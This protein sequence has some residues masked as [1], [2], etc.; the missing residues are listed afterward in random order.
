MD[1][2]TEL[3]ITISKLDIGELRL[4]VRVK[5]LI[6]FVGLLMVVIIGLMLG[7]IKWRPLKK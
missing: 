3:L 6:K 2:L 7:N 4:L 5:E 1:R